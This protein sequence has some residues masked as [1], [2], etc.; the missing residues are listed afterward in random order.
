MIKFIATANENV[1]KQLC[2]HTGLPFSVV[3]KKLR[4][5]QVMI[6][7]VRVTKGNTQKGDE[8][9]IFANKIER[10]FE[11]VY[12]NENVLCI[13]KPSGIETCGENSVEKSLAEKYSYIKA[14][15]RL[16]RNTKGLVL[17]AKNKSAYEQIKEMMKNGLIE[18]T[19]IAKVFYNKIFSGKWYEA[20]LYKNA[21]ES[22][23]KIHQNEEKQTQKIQTWFKTKKQNGMIQ[24]V[25]IHII[26]AKTHQIR[27][28]LAF[29]GAPIVGDQKYGNQE[30]NKKFKVKEQELYATKIQTNFSGDYKYLNDID[31]SYTPKENF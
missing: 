20:Y 5:K 26:S 13:I 21:K 29:L 25:E 16:D 12:E 10:T 7:G 22:F 1:S 31:F 3:N 24:T 9:I 17:F 2:T 15:H 18:K 28:H 27:A 6:N 14:L 11:S 23:V 4:E 19:Y 8:V 30:L